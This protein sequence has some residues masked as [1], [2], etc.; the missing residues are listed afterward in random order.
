MPSQWWHGETSRR[1]VK[2]ILIKGKLELLTPAHLGN[3]ESDAL[4]D[5]P[6]FVDPS[7]RKTPVIYGASLA[8]ALRAYLTQRLGDSARVEALFGGEKGNDAGE[9]SAL[10]VDDALGHLPVEEA[11]IEQ[12]TGVGI[13]AKSRTAQED[14]LYEVDL[15]PAGSIFDLQFELVVRE[16]DKE[17]ELV[18]LL[19]TA[20]EGLS[21]GGITLGARKTRGWGRV[22]VEEWQ[23][24]DFDLREVQGLIDW[25]QQEA[26]WNTSASPAEALGVPSIPTDSRQYFRIEATFAL[27]G[28]M[29]VRWVGDVGDPDLVHIRSYRPGAGG[30]KEVPVLPGTS[31]AGALRARALRILNTLSTSGQS[32]KLVEKIFGP[33]LGAGDG[34]KVRPRA[35][36]LVVEEAE[37]EN[38]TEPLIQTR[39]SIDR[40]TGGTRHGALFTEQPVYAKDETRLRVVLTLRNPEDW[41]IGLLLLLLKDLWTE[42]LPVGGE[43]SVGRGRLRGREASLTLR[44]NGASR[45]WQ[46]AERKEGLE[47]TGEGGAKQLETFVDALKGIL[48]E[49]GWHESGGKDGGEERKI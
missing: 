24:A 23:V 44:R 6:L 36:R 34:R 13:D 31:L 14:R 30:G 33:T 43:A 17:H 48:G 1:I 15:W 4:T 20:L 19:A 45:T 40:F 11:G 39:V 46:I 38:P 10:I 26:Q 3:G 12:R 49:Q 37:I 47:V 42:D 18:E 41:E 27:A 25:I 7:D 9:Q 8:G 32:E 35:S 5:M 16:Q 28:S 2:R 21:D 22:R 29:L